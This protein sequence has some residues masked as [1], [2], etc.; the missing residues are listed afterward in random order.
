MEKFWNKSQG[1]MQAADTC[2]C[3]WTLKDTMSS[4]LECYSRSEYPSQIE[5]DD[6]SDSE[7]KSEEDT[8]EPTELGHFHTHFPSLL[9]FQKPYLCKWDFTDPEEA[10]EYITENFHPNKITNDLQILCS[11]ISNSPTSNLSTTQH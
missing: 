8:L 6:T 7:S 5:L 10:V 9:Q 1:I 2:Q 11:T 3:S 4:S